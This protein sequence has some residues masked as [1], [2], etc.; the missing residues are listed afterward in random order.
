MTP[1]EHFAFRVVMPNNWELQWDM[2]ASP[3]G[4]GTLVTRQGKITQIPILMAPMKLLVAMVGPRYE[5]KFLN[6]MKADLE[7]S[8]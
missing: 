1:N 8:S 5:K 7:S 6:N 3:Q 4:E 2:T